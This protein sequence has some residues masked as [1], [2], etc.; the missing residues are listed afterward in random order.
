MT[1]ASKRRTI[2]ELYVNKSNMIKQDQVQKRGLETIPL[3]PL[4]VSLFLTSTS[5][6]VF[7]V[8][9]TRLFSPMLQYH[10]VF[11][12]TSMAIFGLGIGGYIAYRLTKKMKHAQLVSQLPGLLI[13]L[14]ASYIFSFTLIY[15]LPFLN[16]FIIYAGIAS[17]PFIIGG[18]QIALIFMKLAGDSHKL[19]FADLLGAGAG[20]VLV[21]GLINWLGIVNTILVVSG[22]AVLSSIILSYYLLGRKYMRVPVVIAVLFVMIGM[23]QPGVK[24]FEDRF[25]GY[26]TSPLTSLSSLRSGNISHSLSDWNWDA[27]SRTDVIDTEAPSGSKIITIDGGSNSEMI[28]FDGDFRKV[29]SLKTDLNYLPFEFGSNTKTLI[30]GPGG[31]KDILLALLS[32]SRDIHAVEI[33]TGSVDIARKYSEYNGSIYDRDEVTLHIQDGRNFVKQSNDVYDIIYLAQVMSGAA[34]AVGYSLA[35]NF[36]YT[37]EAIKDYW[38][39]LNEKGRLAFILHDEKDLTRL[40]LTIRESF[41][42]LGISVNQLEKQIVV[43]NRGAPGTSNDMVH[44]PLVMIRKTAYAPEEVK[45]ILVAAMI[46][47]QSPLYVPFITEDYFWDNLSVV[48]SETKAFTLRQDS[49]FSV[50]T[51][52]RPYF[53]DFNSGINNNL[54]YVLAGIAAITFLFFRP[55]FRKIQLKRSPVYFI[56]LGLGFMLIEIPLIQKFSLLLGHPTRAFIV[57]LVALLT[58]GG[59]GSLFG[60]WEK[61]RLKSRYLPLIM[62]PVL[63]AAVYALSDML[64]NRWMIPSSGAR[65][66]VAFLILFPLGFF[67]GMPFPFG[68]RIL[69]LVK[70]KDAVPLMWGINGLMSIGGSTLAVIISMKMGLSYSL[71]TGGF[72][73]LMLFI[74]M[75]VYEKTWRP[76]W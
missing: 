38:S 64:L 76:T 5:L 19:Y 65:A 57:I 42:E 53:F 37:K 2:W 75:P 58:G 56:G 28:Q 45:G 34:E 59:L 60:G 31:G 41:A 17:L 51:D 6:F 44:M 36:I 61:F 1:G 69:S 46:N 67:L 70:K 15:K 33:N 52:N 27:Y 4:L 73:Y 13:I 50:T 11:M 48:S 10:F 18:I 23:F 21:V 20:S 35:E 54:L 32:G 40:L 29:Q 49:G 9:L 47:G 3:F 26:F 66:F 74:F 39:K 7:E 25:R 43:I 30:I 55:A 24:Q 62:V 12:L 22:F 16:F 63:T 14:A 72:I 71:I 68:L 8:T